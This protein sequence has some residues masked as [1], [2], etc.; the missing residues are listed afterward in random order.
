MPPSEDKQLECFFK[1]IHK[2]ASSIKTFVEKDSFIR[3]YCHHD[4]DGIAA[5]A[6]IGRSLNRLGA[7][8][9]TRVVKQ[10]SAPL[11]KEIA[12]EPSS[13]CIFTDLGSGYLDLLGEYL[14][15]ME[16]VVLD[17]HKPSGEAFPELVQAN[18]HPAG[19]DGARDV[20]GSGMA[21]YVA[22][23]LDPKNI[24][25][26]PIAVVG[27]LGDFQDKNEE[28]KLRGLNTPIVEDGITAGVLKVETDLLFFGRETRPI[29]KALSRTTNP[30][31][32]GLS[33]HEDKCLGFLVNL[34]F[35]LKDGNQ[36]RTL[37]GLSKDE[38]QLLFS[39][40]VEYMIDAGSSSSSALRL[41]GQVYILVQEERSTFLRDGREFS[42]LLNACAR[43]RKTGL[44]LAICMGDRGSSLSDAET[45]LGEYRRRL[46][47]YL[48][49]V[50]GNQGDIEETESCY[51]LRG[52]DVIDER[53]IGSV[54]SI[55]VTSGILNPSKPLISL[56]L[57]DEGTIKVSARASNSLLEKGLNL[58]T[59]MQKAAGSSKGRGGG[60]D[61]AAGALLPKE[62][63]DTFLRVVRQLLNE[64]L[65][66]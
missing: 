39:K 7:N 58:G 65:N 13:P 27:A 24:D 4:A 8:F 60:H 44:A 23:N 47:E 46:A 21:Y 28:Q 34:G 48:E 25:L 38:K 22:R 51:I 31:I 61:V 56:T 1:S 10:I 32:P 9:R 41:V 53:M 20:S 45:A 62:C 15:G 5:G 35:Q 29:H 12:S 50:T 19:F 55:L 36:W 63:E 57:T 26:S 40:L 33:G 16:V 42:S 3:V 64:V 6:I 37:A 43:T 18:P 66:Q 14:G 30:Y 54:S 52:K 17:H 59:V 49:W 11:I 2:A